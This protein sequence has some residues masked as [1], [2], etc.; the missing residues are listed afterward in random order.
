[1]VI[2]RGN[3]GELFE[4]YLK[5]PH[6]HVK[7]SSFVVEREWMAAKLALALDLP[8]APPVKVHLSQEFI[9]SMADRQLQRQLLSGPEIIFGSLSAGSGW[10]IWTEAAHMPRNKLALATSI[11]LFDTVIQNWDRCMPNPNLLQKGDD[12]LLI[13]HEEAFVEATGSDA[14]KDYQKAPWVR[15]AISNHTGYDL[16]HPLWR[17]LHPA[18]QVDFQ[19]AAATWKRLPSDAFT[20]YAR[21]AP[22]CWSSHATFA[23]ADYLSN[24]TQRIDEITALIEYNFSR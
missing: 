15:G 7:K 12:L 22:A 13:D 14:E 16:E 10:N 21:D 8:C 18:T 4:V 9:A 5:S 23:I 17:K 19:Q 3:G 2:V 1:M 6:F 20:L 11:Y 24:A